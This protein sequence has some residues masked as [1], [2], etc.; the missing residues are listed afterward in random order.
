MKRNRYYKVQI[1]KTAG[2]VKAAIIG[3]KDAPHRPEDRYKYNPE[4][5]REVYTVWFDDLDIAQAA[6][7]EALKDG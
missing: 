7:K 5:K 2:S 4:I 3:H 6:V 1:E